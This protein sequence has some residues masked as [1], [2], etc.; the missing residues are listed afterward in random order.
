MSNSDDRRSED[1]GRREYDHMVCPMHQAHE[2][3]MD[4]LKR[5]VDN[6]VKQSEFDHLEIEVETKL[7][8]WIF[9]LFVTSIVIFITIASAAYGWI[10]MET[11]QRKADVVLLTANQAKLMRYFDI[12]PVGS[13][14]EAKR[15]MEGLDN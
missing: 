10:A 13:R 15:L 4:T 11:V 14:E 8:R 5:K 1:P 3:C 12:A 2:K 9:V 7:D 6:R